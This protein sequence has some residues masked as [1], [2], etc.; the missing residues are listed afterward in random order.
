M[1][2]D[3]IRF[4]LVLLFCVTMSVGVHAAEVVQ[5]NEE[6]YDTYVPQGK[7]VDAIYGDYVIRNKHL[8]AVIANPIPGRNANMTTS[9]VGGHIIDLSVRGGQTSDQLTC[10][11]A[12]NRKYPLRRAVV[13]AGKG[14][15]V[16]IKCISPPVDGVVYTV[17]YELRDDQPFIQVNSHWHNTSDKTV[18]VSFYDYVRADRTFSRGRASNRKLGWIYD[19]WW[20]QAYGFM[21]DGELE[22]KPSGRAFGVVYLIDG[23][24]GAKIK[25]GEQ[26]QFNR[27]VIPGATSLDVREAANNISGTAQH[28]VKVHIEDSRGGIPNT[29]VTVKMGKSVYAAGYT[30]SQGHFEAKLPKGKYTLDILA[31]AQR[32]ATVEIEA[33][34]SATIPHIKLPDPGFVQVKITDHNGKAIPGKVQFNGIEGTKTPM[35]FDDTGEHAVRNCYYTHNGNFTQTIAPGQYEVVVSYGPEYDAVITNIVV[36]R[37]ATTNLN[38]MLKRSVR[39][40]GWVSTEYHSHSSPSGDNVSSQFGRVLNLLGE[41]LEYAPCTEHNRIDTYM[42]HLKK[43]NAVHLMATTTGME[44]TGRDLPVNHHNVFPLKHYPR[45]QDGGGPQ[46]DADPVVQI[47]RIYAWDDQ[48]DKLIQQNHP[49]LIRHVF[50]RNSD[51]KLD[52]GYRGMLPYMDVIEVH[53]IDQILKPAPIK[54]GKNTGRNRMHDWMVLLNQGYRIP[55]VINT[56]SHYN[57]HGSGWYRNYVK[58]KTDDPAEID[59]QDMVR[60]SEAGHIV[61]TTGPYLEVLA[62]STKWGVA[63]PGDEMAAL[64]GKVKL[65]IRVQCS[66]WLDV[67]RIQIMRNGKRDPKLNFTRKSHPDM[68]KDGIVKFENLIE[69]TIEEDTH[70]IV[71]AAGEGLQLGKVYG[72][73]RGKMMPIAVA[74]PVY[75]DIDGNGFKGNGD[76]LDTPAFKK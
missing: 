52:G 43:L 68:F 29:V 55:G 50:D 69:V 46:I 22:V 26:A 27:K 47:K 59:T 25:A 54:D 10:I 73:S 24:S 41:H 19:E 44:L 58:S 33:G 11:Y 20:K 32:K 56:D 15:V 31:P 75:L 30:D 65:H 51:G 7:E 38:A 16:R 8:V 72:A 63:I 42:P 3:H 17:T 2:F 74:N 49:N 76:M 60:S 34:S 66:N 18:S 13:E 45:T 23:Q 5:L 21:A 35:W 37:G 62:Q 1:K 48:S 12:G 36:T 4:I 39:T 14:D 28:P 57:F 71:V 67:N 61:M 64:D 53:P 70:L 40:P 6:N 9:G